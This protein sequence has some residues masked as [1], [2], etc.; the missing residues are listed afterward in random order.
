VCPGSFDPVTNGHFDIFLRAAAMFEELTVA[1]FHN[2]IKQQAMFSV[3]E[4]VDMLKECTKD[5]PNVQVDAFS[6]LLPEY[7]KQR[8]TAVI[9]R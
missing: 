1:V 4:R 8:N 6:G 2:P 9:L 5:I 3:E 7:L